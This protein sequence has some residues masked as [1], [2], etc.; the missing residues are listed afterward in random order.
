MNNRACRAA[1]PERGEMEEFLGCST[2]RGDQV[3]SG[4][5]V[6]RADRGS[7][8]DRVMERRGRALETC[9]GAFLSTQQSTDGCA[10]AKKILEARGKDPI[11]E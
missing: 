8:Q 7:S 5:P 1:T 6:G 4:S 9:R 11:K 10:H 3:E 2:G